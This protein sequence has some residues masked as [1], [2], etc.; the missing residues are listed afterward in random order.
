MIKF[1]YKGQSV[2]AVLDKFPTAKIISQDEAG[3]IISAEVFGDG[4]D[5]WVKSQG[6]N[7]E[8]FENE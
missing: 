8:L 3:Y 1:R 7:V 5:M 2:E 6:D 4:V